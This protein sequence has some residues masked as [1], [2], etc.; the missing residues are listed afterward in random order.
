MYMAEDEMRLMHALQGETALIVA[1]ARGDVYDVRLLVAAGSNV[2]ARA[3]DSSTALMAAASGA[4]LDC[5]K[6]LVECGADVNMTKKVTS[7]VSS[8]ADR[9]IDRRRHLS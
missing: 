7:V 9:H 3:R 6:V 1:S 2:N 8:R 5:A 4:F